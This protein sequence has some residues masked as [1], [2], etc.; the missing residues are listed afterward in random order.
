MKPYMALILLIS[1]LS[2]SC[3]RKE[4][5]TSKEGSTQKLRIGISK[6]VSH[7]ALD[8]VEQNIKEVLQNSGLEVS[9]DSQNANGEITAANS[10]AQL[11]Q[12]QK[13][14]IAIGIATPTAQ[15]LVQNLSGIPIFYSAITDPEDAG[16]LSKR[17]SGMQITGYSDLTPV[18]EQIANIKRI[19]PDIKVLGQIFS[20]D[21]ANARILNEMTESAARDNNL[22]LV[23]VSVSNTA[24]VRDTALSIIDRIDALY[25]TTDNKIISALPSLGEVAEQY[26]IPLY[27]ADP[28]TTEG[29]KVAVAMGFDYGKM[30]EATGDLIVRY[31]NGDKSVFEKPVHYMLALEHQLFIINQERIEKLGLT[32]PADIA[33]AAQ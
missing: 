29:S 22:E 15:A 24:E 21:E 20:S 33:Q 11:F 4:K 7:P 9:F 28:T 1:L 31:L 17:D 6:I 14:D 19:Q 12:N 10:I 25:I 2:L 23:S 30:G 27:T 32:I 5:E 8:S 3:N 26:N 13:V 16:L 18:S